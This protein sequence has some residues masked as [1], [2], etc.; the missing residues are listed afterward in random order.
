MQPEV[1]KLKELHRFYKTGAC[2]KLGI[3]KALGVNRKAV[4]RWF[5]SEFEPSVRHLVKIKAL[6][7]D[8]EA[9]Q[10]LDRK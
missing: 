2:S 4:Q 9:K 10:T 5:N 7:R 6:I 8:L 3:A 1:E